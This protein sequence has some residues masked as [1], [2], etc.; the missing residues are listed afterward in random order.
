MAKPRQPGKDFEVV[1]KPKAR[2][3]RRPPPAPVTDSAYLQAV[4]GDAQ[5]PSVP[6]E[7]LPSPPP[8]QVALDGEL[9][10]PLPESRAP[11]TADEFLSR[12][13]ELWE[14][15]Q[16][17]FL[18]IG[19]LLTLA[20]TR[21]TDDDRQALYDGLNRRFGKSAR[22]QLMSAYRAIRDRVVPQEMAAAGYGT[23]YMLARLTDEQRSRAA[24]EGLLRPDIRQAEI[25]QFFQ[26]ARAP[27]SRESRIAELEA[28]EAKLLAEL[29]RVRDELARER[30]QV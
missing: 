27:M 30:R 25:R 1:H 20:E 29:A 21:L 4:M 16:Q 6:V 18:R 7:I 5:K 3:S 24:A 8:G 15:A 2:T 26:S 11:R 10:P 19:E 14:D 12:I 22:S 28:R 9:F 17:R 13:T 23:V